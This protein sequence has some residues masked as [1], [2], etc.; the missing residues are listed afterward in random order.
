MPFRRTHSI[1]EIGEACLSIDATLSDMVDRGAPLSEYAWL[2]RYPGD[3]PS[4]TREETQ[5]CLALAHEVNAASL[6]RLPV[7]A[8]PNA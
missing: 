4:P 1:E 2:Y 5:A 6:E 7:E 3:P 8:R